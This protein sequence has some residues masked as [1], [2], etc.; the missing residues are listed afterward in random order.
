MKQFLVASIRENCPAAVPPSLTECPNSR[1]V[2]VCLACLRVIT[3]EGRN[4][5]AANEHNRAFIPRIPPHAITNKLA[6]IDAPSLLTSLNYIG[7]ILIK[8]VRPLQVGRREFIYRMILPH[9]IHTGTSDTQAS[10][11]AV[12]RHYE[13]SQGRHAIYAC[14]TSD[15]PQ[16]HTGDPS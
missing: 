10:C 3:A 12:W 7:D 1:S 9:L 8:R 5:R 14:P 4:R 15:H 6:V 11:V 2:D 13:R 16:L